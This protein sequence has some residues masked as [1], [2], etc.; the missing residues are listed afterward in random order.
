[1]RKYIVAGNWKMNTNHS[2]AVN[3]FNSL[4]ALGDSFPSNVEVMV[5][6]PYVYLNELAKKENS[7][8]E[9]VSQN[10][11]SNENG[12]YTGEISAS[13]L[14]SIGVRTAIVGHSERRHVFGESIRDVSEKVLMLL[15][16]NMQVIFC[17]G[18]QLNERKTN[19]HFKV[20]NDQL[21]SIL[22]LEPNLFDKIIVAYEPVWAI[23][24]GETASPE[25]AQEMHSFIRLK[26]T[27]VYGNQANQTR[28]LYGGSVKP[29]NAN[30]IF[31]KADVDGGL[32][33]GASMDA[34]VFIEVIKA[35]G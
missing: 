9:V 12:A 35:A 17:V 30:E 19:A 5:A 4:T 2:E 26:L 10:C 6:P 22:S 34:S 24:T 3:L 15:S 13:M 27:E 14:K 1:M 11:A 25:Q 16:Q 18:E 8:V 29:A 20:I 31:A 32:V 23:G 28:I 21:E 7:G 33:G